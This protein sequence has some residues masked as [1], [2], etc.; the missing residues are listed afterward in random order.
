MELKRKRNFS[1]QTDMH[2]AIA[3]QIKY[4]INRTTGIIAI[5]LKDK[6]EAMKATIKTNSSPGKT[7]ITIESSILNECPFDRVKASAIEIFLPT[8]A[9]GIINPT[10][11]RRDRKSVV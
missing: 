7:I 5:G 9:P 11:R 2:T 4:P 8:A 3:I 6:L 10:R 1:Y